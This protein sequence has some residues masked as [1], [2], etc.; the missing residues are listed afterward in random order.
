L[1]GFELAADS[2]FISLYWGDIVAC[3][4]VWEWEKWGAGAKNEGFLG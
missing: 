2:I 1:R 4:Y 3:V